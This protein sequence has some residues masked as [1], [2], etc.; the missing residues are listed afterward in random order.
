MNKPLAIKYFELAADEG[1]ADGAG[2]ADRHRLTGRWA[3][4]VTM[5]ETIHKG[6]VDECNHHKQ[7][8]EEAMRG[9][10]DKMDI[11]QATAELARAMAQ[12]KAI[13]LLRKKR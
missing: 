11:T 2:H 4:A 8:A 9:H 5:S 1:Y 7:R 6:M 10:S 12:L 13:A 3:V